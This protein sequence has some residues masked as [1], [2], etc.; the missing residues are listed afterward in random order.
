MWA[1]SN[2]RRLRAA[3]TEPSAVGGA[4]IKERRFD[5]ERVPDRILRALGQPRWWQAWYPRPLRD[6]ANAWDEIPF[7]MKLLRTIVWLNLLALPLAV[8]LIFLVPALEKVAASAGL[9]LP[10]SM[11]VTI[12]A[13]SIA[14]A[15]RLLY[16]LPLAVAGTVV[17]AVRRRVPVL[18]AI[19][20]LFTWDCDRW[21]STE[22]RRLIG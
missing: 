17:I 22:A 5:F 8:P 18:T 16:G 14:L 11:R 13:S 9:Q 3:R 20:L 6:P 10:L 12:F 4:T 21:S 1:I 19:K 2:D 15:A 7:A